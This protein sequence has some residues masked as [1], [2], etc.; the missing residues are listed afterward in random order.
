M[1]WLRS[2]I[3]KVK[4]N[5]KENKLENLLWVVNVVPSIFGF[6]LLKDKISAPF[7]IV[8]FFLLFYIYI[9]GSLWYLIF[10]AETASEY[11]TIYV[12]VAII[13]LA[14]NNASWWV[15]KRTS[16]RVVIT[17]LNKNDSLVTGSDER[18][19]RHATMIRNIKNIIL[20]F[21]GGIY[22]SEIFNYLPNRVRVT[23]D[24]AMVPC[25]GIIKDPTASPNREIC[26]AMLFVQECAMMVSVLNYQALLIVLIAHT[27]AMY[28]LLADELLELNHQAS[29]LLADELL[30]LN[31]QG[32]DTTSDTEQSFQTYI[33]QRL[34]TFVDRHCY[35]IQITGYLR[36]LY[37]IP[38]GIGFGYCAI[39]IILCSYL[40]SQDMVKFYPVLM[41]CVYLF[42]MFCYL[43]QRLINAAEQ[44]ES[45][46]YCC[47]WERFSVRN[48]RTV[49]NMLVLAQRPVALLAADIIPINI[50]TF[51]TTTQAM[52]KFATVVKV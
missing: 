15:T 12:N 7:W 9:L 27:A 11:V 36:Q 52:Y 1:Q 42:F 37:S 23:Q 49:Y 43:G 13:I 48:R 41:Y 2:S 6:S 20:I 50:D 24:Y 40:N 31:H 3:A 19:R 25:V 44:F 5:F 16:L 26:M 33:E 35:L 18:R 22:L 30:E 38:I 34:I 45:A 51:A 32:P 10:E 29:D 4:L 14:A 47:G 8:N 21:Y 46:A 17:L 28:E 39:C